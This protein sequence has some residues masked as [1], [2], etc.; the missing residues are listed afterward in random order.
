MKEMLG[1]LGAKRMVMGHTVQRNGINPACDEKGWRID[2][3]MSK[4]FSGPI[5]ALAIEGD[6]V[7]VLKEA[8]GKEK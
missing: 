3:G 2:V 7:T 6:V 5:Q 4:F 8:N 1:M